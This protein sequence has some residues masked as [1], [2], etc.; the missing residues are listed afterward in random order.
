MTA[1][2]SHDDVERLRNT[3]LAVGS[4]ARCPGLHD[5]NRF[6]RQHLDDPA[7][8]VEDDVQCEIDADHAPDLLDVLARRIGRVCADSRRRI[9]HPGVIAVDRLESGEPDRRALDSTRVPGELMGLDRA[10]DDLQVRLN[11]S[12]VDPHRGSTRRVVEHHEVLRASVVGDHA[13]AIEHLGREDLGEL[14]RGHRCVTADGHVERDR[15]V[16][17]PLRSELLEQGRQ[18]MAVGYRTRLVVDGDRDGGRLAPRE[19]AEGMLQ[20]LL[21]LGGRIDRRLRLGEIDH[22]HHDPIGNIGREEGSPVGNTNGLHEHSPGGMPTTDRTT[23][24][25]APTRSRARTAGPSWRMKRSELTRS[26]RAW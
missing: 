15:I 2:R 18:E 4:H 17:Y 26:G 13:V 24:Q 1:R 3:D 23:C 12:A 5:G 9:G 22:F 7:L 6:A 14:R 16:C 21:R 20:R 10:D 19:V 25:A 8:G 11:V